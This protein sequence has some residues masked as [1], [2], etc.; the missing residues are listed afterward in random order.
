MAPGTVI[1]VAGGTYPVNYL[2]FQ[3]RVIMIQ[4]GWSPDFT[5]RD[6]AA[7]RTALDGQLQAEVLYFSIDSGEQSSTPGFFWHTSAATFFPSRL[8]SRAYVPLIY[9]V[10]TRARHVRAPPTRACVRARRAYA[11]SS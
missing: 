8:L 6:L 3:P 10:R 4:G 7:H 2:T 9:R 1:R 11:P 5:E